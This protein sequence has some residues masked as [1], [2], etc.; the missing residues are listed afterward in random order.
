[1][2]IILQNDMSFLDFPINKMRKEITTLSFEY[3]Q[4]QEYNL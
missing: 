4:E 1:M 2:I 3:F